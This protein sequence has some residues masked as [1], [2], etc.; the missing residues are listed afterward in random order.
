MK[1]FLYEL[2]EPHKQAARLIERFTRHHQRGGFSAGQLTVRSGGR[3]L[4]QCAVG[5]KDF[6]MRFMPMAQQTR[7][8]RF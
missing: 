7:K 5:N 2:G 4:A 1:D 8:L 6:F 3:V